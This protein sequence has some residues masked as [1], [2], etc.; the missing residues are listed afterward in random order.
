MGQAH[1]GDAAAWRE[2][3]R[4]FH[5]I[6]LRYLQSRWVRSPE[7]VAADVWLLVHQGLGGLSGEESE[8]E[9][10]A[11]LVTIARH[12]LVDL[13]RW[14]RRRPEEVPDL[15]HD[16]Y[17]SEDPA[18]I[19]VTRRVL[20]DAISTLAPPQDEIV[21]LRLLGSLGHAEIAVELNMT[22]AA[23]RKAYSRALDQLRKD[24]RNF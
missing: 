2:L 15:P 8:D 24:L 14:A 3:V 6:L 23:V 1:D 16:G 13:H 18:S 19:V 22:T 9:F 11:W 12:R 21:R 5:P 7:D 20:L 10:R 17:L 4:R